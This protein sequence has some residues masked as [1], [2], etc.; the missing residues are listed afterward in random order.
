MDPDVTGK[1]NVK[2]FADVVFGREKPRQPTEKED[3]KKK[4]KGGKG[5]K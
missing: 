4:K 1:I 5:K 2:E 3:D